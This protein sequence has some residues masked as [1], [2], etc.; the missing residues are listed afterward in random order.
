MK[1]V[2]PRS[3]SVSINVL[4]IVHAGYAFF[5]EQQVNYSTKIAYRVVKARL[6]VSTLTRLRIRK[7]LSGGI[8]VFWDF[9]LPKVY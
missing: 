2:G 8:R 4:T 6:S 3:Q 7:V 9:Q 1:L 5:S